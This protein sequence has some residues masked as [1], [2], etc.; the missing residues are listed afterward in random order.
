[1]NNKKIKVKIIENSTFEEL[2]YNINDYLE[3]YVNEKDIID[4][5]YQ[6][7]HDECSAMIIFKEEYL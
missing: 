4:I 5:K 2:E 7:T 1:M 3:N 6:V